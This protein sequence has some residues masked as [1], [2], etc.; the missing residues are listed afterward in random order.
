VQHT[1]EITHFF[2]KKRSFLTFWTSPSTALC[3]NFS[4]TCCFYF[5][6]ISGGL[7]HHLGHIFI[8]RRKSGFSVFAFWKKVWVFAKQ[9]WGFVSAFV[10]IEFVRLPF[11][12]KTVKTIR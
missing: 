5:A 10:G 2:T 11:A 12:E 8:F 3:M 4:E 1:T 7:V 6:E 9:I